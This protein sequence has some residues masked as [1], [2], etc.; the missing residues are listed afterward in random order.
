[1][2][3]KKIIDYERPGVQASVEMQ[4]A[5]WLVTEENRQLRQLLLRFVYGKEIETYLEGGQVQTNKRQQRPGGAQM[6]CI[7]PPETAS[8][9]R[10][11]PV[12]SL[13]PT[14]HRDPLQT[15]CTVAASIPTDL[16][17]STYRD[18]AEPRSALSC[19]GPESCTV[20]NSRVFAFMG[21][22]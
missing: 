9:E 5:A 14:L 13:L 19:T 15:E 2:P 17:S 11:L 4:T 7:L 22:A 8:V 10:P 1:M 3:R 20:G 18:K 6:Y 21:P 12:D 16:H